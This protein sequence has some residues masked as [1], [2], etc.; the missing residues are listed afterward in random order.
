MV[1]RAG[2]AV[3]Q[4]AEDREGVAYALKFFLD[5]EAFHSEAD[6]YAACSTAAQHPSTGAV[7]GMPAGPAQFLPRVESM[8]KSSSDPRGALLPPCIVMEKGE[9]LQ[10]WCNR[11]EPDLFASIAVRPTSIKLPASVVLSCLVVPCALCR[12]L[13]WIIEKYAICAGSISIV[14]SWTYVLCRCCHTY[15]PGW[16]TCMRRGTCTATSSRPT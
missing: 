8:C 1:W 9:S 2:Q 5:I 3:V 12:C 15:L 4:F 13:C 10:E 14:Q 11:A 7:L 16:R 6:L